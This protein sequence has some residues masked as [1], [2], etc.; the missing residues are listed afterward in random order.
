MQKK[1]NW[2]SRKYRT[3]WLLTALS[4]ITLTGPYIASLFLNVGT[5]EALIT[6]S[7]W[8]TFL[9]SIWGIYFGA[10]ILERHQAFRSK[11]QTKIT[12]SDPLMDDNSNEK[13]VAK[14]K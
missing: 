6:G 12:N 11:K 7:Q 1:N 3:A 10:N 4:T 13:N 9:F 8:L 2:S 5:C 14:E